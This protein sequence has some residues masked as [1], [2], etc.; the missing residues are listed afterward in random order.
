MCCVLYSLLTNISHNEGAK[1]NILESIVQGTDK[2]QIVDDKH[3]S[4][5]FDAKKADNDLKA[6]PEC[7]MVWQIRE[8][9][10]TVEFKYYDS[11]PSYGKVKK[12]CPRCKIRMKNKYYTNSEVC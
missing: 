6:C 4:Y 1:M 10:D 8:F 11:V 7:K 9:N 5:N 3:S 12:V 2:V